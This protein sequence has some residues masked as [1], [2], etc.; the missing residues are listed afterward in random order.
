V[1][2]EEALHRSLFP[3]SQLQST[4]EEAYAVATAYV[5]APCVMVVDDEGEDG[6]GND[7]E[8]EAADG[9]D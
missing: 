6:A 5:R 8:M 2:R 7:V 3:T 1:R 9:T 4:S